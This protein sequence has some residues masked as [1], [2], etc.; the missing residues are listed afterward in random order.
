MR[1]RRFMLYGFSQGQEYEITT[2][3]KLAMKAEPSALLFTKATDLKVHDR[4]KVC[5]QKQA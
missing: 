1:N 3:L 2:I 5:R 4:Q